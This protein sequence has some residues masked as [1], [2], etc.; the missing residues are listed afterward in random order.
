VNIFSACA[1]GVLKDEM[2]LILGT[3]L[4]EALSFS[5]F[6]EDGDFLLSKMALL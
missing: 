6:T 5:S 4:R 1:R 3:V 2:D